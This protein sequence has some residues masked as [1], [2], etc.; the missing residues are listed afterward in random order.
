MQ[1]ETVFLYA[2][3][4]EEGPIKLGISRNPEARVRELQ[5]GCPFKLELLLVTPLSSRESA[6]KEEVNVHDLFAGHHL[7]GEWF[8]IDVELAGAG[9]D[10]V[11][12]SSRP[13]RGRLAA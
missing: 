5:C 1:N 11:I 4:K 12:A 9:I 3:G 2:I 7:H 6:A 10:A 8:D 13:R